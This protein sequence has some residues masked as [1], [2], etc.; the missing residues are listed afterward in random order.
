MEHPSASD[1]GDG[2][3]ELRHE[4]PNHL[5]TSVGSVAVDVVRQF[6]STATTL[7][8]QQSRD[9]NPRE[10]LT[11]LC[12]RYVE[13]TGAD[14]SSVL[15]VDR[16]HQVLRFAAGYGRTALPQN[17]EPIPLDQ[18]DTSHVR[19][20]RTGEPVIVDDTSAWPHEA[21][22]RDQ[23]VDRG[24]HRYWVMPLVS[25]DGECLG[26]FGVSW[27]TGPDRDAGADQSSDDQRWLFEEFGLLGA[28]II[29]RRR[30]HWERI[31][32]IAT[33]R[34]RIAGELHDDPVQAM[35]AVS[36]RLQGLQMRLDDPQQ[37]E[38]VE[39]LRVSV[40]DAIER[41][42]HM[43]FTL[44][45]PTLREDGLVVT[46]RV[47]LESYVEP[48]GMTWSITGDEELRLAEDVEVLAFR[49]CR[50]AVINVLKHAQASSIAIT[51]A[52]DENQE[53]TVTIA[54]DGVGFDPGVAFQE[55]PGHVGLSYA[56][57]LAEA[58]GGTY[59]IESAP[60]SGSTVT[61][62]IPII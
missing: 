54:D 60:G 21:E 6:A 61:F 34:E 4:N 15:L 7:L 46:L 26:T 35:T 24:A 45:S 38:A 23:V 50:G 55:R 1:H 32:L 36:L 5:V 8:G 9:T 56:R 25:I 10:T 44:A 18:E 58:V 30:S 40:N 20:C 39:A 47:Y 28:A 57:S 11:A 37:Q 62:T 49:L 41:L 2:R 53:L 29:E 3:Q 12:R 59:S 33:E 19:A 52:V 42:R 43:L 51:V 16:Q 27:S 13:I 48:A 31:G 14:G 17:L 22:I